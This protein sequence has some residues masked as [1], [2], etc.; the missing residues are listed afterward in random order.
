MN[1][2]KTILNL[3]WEHWGVTSSIILFILE[4][5]LRRWPTKNNVSIIDNVR[6]LLDFIQQNKR[7]PQTKD[8]YLPLMNDFNKVFVKR[9][10]HILPII[11]F[12]CVT[13]NSFS[14]SPINVQARSVLF[15]S[16]GTQDTTGIRN[17]RTSLQNI[18]G[19]T[20]GLF[21]DEFNNKWRVWNGITW[22]N[23][24]LFNASN[25]FSG[26]TANTLVFAN[27]TSSITSTTATYV[28]GRTTFT[29]TATVS[30]LNIGSFAGN[31][32][33]LIN[34]D[35][36]YNSSTNG[37]SM[38]VNGATNLMLRTTA[39][40]TTRIPFYTGTNGGVA[41][42]ADLTFTAGTT[43]NTAEIDIN[44]LSAV[45]GIAF[46]NSAGSVL[47]NESALTYDATTNLMLLS[48]VAGTHATSIFGGEIQLD[49]SGG[50]DDVTINN[51]GINVSGLAVPWVI[52]TDNDLELESTNQLILD[53]DNVE[54]PTDILLFGDG[55][56]SMTLQGAHT[57][58]TLQIL[59]GQTNTTG[60]G[61]TLSLKGGQSSNVNDSGGDVIIQGG[62]GSGSGSAN[63][64]DVQIIVGEGAGLIS[65]SII[66]QTTT[67]GTNGQLRMP[68]NTGLATMAA[69]TV[70]VNYSAITAN[71]RIFLT[72]QTP[73]GTPGFLRISARTPGTS[74]TIL[75]SSGTDTSVVGWMVIEP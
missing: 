67:A 60:S 27:T 62:A 19:N 47:D 28:S 45:N 44:G 14:Q 26:L 42:D 21:F 30:G 59:A 15:T 38:Y 74:F 9:D 35:F 16:P 41:D 68:S 7:K 40:A 72:C 66:L 49:F 23:W 2:L 56:N 63:G 46:Q 64:G 25:V 69:G 36:F 70:T 17:T 65:G 53:V 54:T 13:F 37:V 58:A 8:E 6:K 73:G 55:T 11:I 52:T 75:S 39:P 20:S 34:G 4:I 43:L 1:I 3:A 22:V 57:N 50:S 33:T 18:N 10:R 31:P 24:N 29:P 12:L 61:S 71:S 32:S 51:A 5:I 48:N